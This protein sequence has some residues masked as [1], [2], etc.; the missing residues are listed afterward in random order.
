MNSE[1]DNL[2]LVVGLESEDLVQELRDELSE[3][4]NLEVVLWQPKEF[5]R[6]ANLDAE[7]FP[8]TAAEQ[9][10]S[11]PLIDSAQVL[12]APPADRARLGLP[13]YIVAGGA[14]SRPVEDTGQVFSLVLRA[15]IRT[16]REHNN[17]HV[18]PPIFRI[19]VSGHWFGLDELK[20]DELARHLASL[21]QGELAVR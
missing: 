11:V 16:V 21:S 19:G 5:A 17:A 20:A 14:M 9:W 1:M 6:R 12:T 3:A 8:I 10:G 4:K 2:T 13:M 18:I 7:F 15:A